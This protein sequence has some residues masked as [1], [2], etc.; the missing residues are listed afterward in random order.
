MK[1]VAYSK[2]KGYLD[3]QSYF[4]KLIKEWKYINRLVDRYSTILQRVLL[5]PFIVSTATNSSEQNSDHR[6][7][8]LK[9]AELRK[10]LSEVKTGITFHSKAITETR[11]ALTTAYNRASQLSCSLRG[12]NLETL[13]PLINKSRINAG[14]ISQYLLEI[15]DVKNWDKPEGVDLVNEINNLAVCCWDAMHCLNIVLDIIKLIRPEFI[16][17][18]L[19]EKESEV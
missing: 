13:S 17:Q 1:L 6:L 7:G 5:I 14:N 10:E 15:R 2:A 8:L 18:H 19:P 12:I 4:D 16:F 9:V 3:V 11:D